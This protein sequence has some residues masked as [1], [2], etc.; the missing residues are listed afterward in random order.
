MWRGAKLYD[1]TMLVIE[2]LVFL[3]IAYEVF[4]GRLHRWK[5]NRRTRRARESFVKGRALQRDVPQK[6]SKREDVS[7]WRETVQNWITTTDKLLAGYSPQA[8]ASF[9]HDP[10]HMF[11]LAITHEIAAD[12]EHR[13]TRL[14]D[15]LNNLRE[16]I[17][18][19]EVYF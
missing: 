3:L 4:G 13:Y 11:R 7:Q 16:I 2:L 14:Q 9:L 18:N 19:P 17:E 15:C 12:A 8:S 10:G 1:R 5:L 6:D